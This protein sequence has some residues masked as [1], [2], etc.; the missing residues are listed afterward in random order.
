MIGGILK[1]MIFSLMLIIPSFSSRPD[2]T[3]SSQPADL[4]VPELTLDNVYREILFRG[5]KFPEIVLKQVVCE[6][7]WLKCKQCSMKFNNLF[8]FTTR[9]GYMKFKTWVDCIKFYKQWQDKLRLKGNEN[10]YTV[11]TNAH[12]AVF[13]DYNL[14]LRSIPVK[15]ITKKFE[16]PMITL[17]SPV[18]VLVH[19]GK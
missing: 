12:F 7:M 17:P 4:M 9:N 8:G 13:E 10:Y 11:L 15:H 1:V 2:T 5:I 16:I 6:T 14:R 3:N 18:D 19:N